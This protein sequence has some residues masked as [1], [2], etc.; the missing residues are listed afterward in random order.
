MS[1]LAHRVAW[2]IATGEWP[3]GHLDHRNGDP[4]DNR[5]ENLRITS[6]T[7]NRWNTA[8]KPKTSRFKGVHRNQRGRWVAKIRENNREHYLGRFTSELA[9]ARAYDDAAMKYHGDFARLN[10]PSNQETKS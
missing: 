10:F 4:S 3:V 5:F 8:P 2:A 6:P 7:Q 9:A 1:F